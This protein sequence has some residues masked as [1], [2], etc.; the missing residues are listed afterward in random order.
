MRVVIVG[1]SAAGLLAALLLARAGH[2]VIVL[3][4]DDLRPAGDVEQ[5]AAS[6]F[7]A[8]A[9]QI[10]QPHVVLALCRELMLTHL[11]DL[12]A[13]LLEAGVVE[14]SLRSQ[15]APTLADRSDQPGDER[16]PLVLSRRATVDWVLRRW[17]AAEPGVEVRGRIRVTGL[18]ARPG[19][20]PR[21]VGVRTDTGEL[22]ADL[23]VDAAGR[24]TPL[25]GWLCDIGGRPSMLSRAECGVAYISRQYRLRTTD[26]L[27]GPPTTRRVAAL[28]QFTVGIWG[29]DH[30]SM[31][32]ALAPLVADR[33]FR[34]ANRPDV[35]A[36]VLRS[37]PYYAAWLDVLDPITDVRVMGGLHNTLRRLV[38]DGRPV[39]LG[40]LAVGDTV[41]TTNPTLA[42]G[43]SLTLR[44][45]VDLLEA[46]DKHAE[47]PTAQ[48]LAMDAAVDEHIAPFYADQ[49]AIDADRLAALRHAVLGAPPPPVVS[50]V[51][52]EVSDRV[53]YAE[54]RSAAP[55]DPG[56][57][58]AYSRLM[59][60]LGLPDDIYRDQALAARVREVIAERGGA[61]PMA[62]PDTEQLLTALATG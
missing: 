61:P 11:P 45:V 47:D 39:V 48:A 13:G 2:E 55:W 50:A 10:V 41:C 32:L 34:R 58:R 28:E 40:L 5:A 17:A 51:S 44:G 42:R 56:A 27:P 16:M 43:L 36:A 6:A 37:V 7:R 12:Y 59:G 21:V 14:A 46:L 49:A 38:V 29:G 22:A 30:G 18:L 9:P 33:R 23:V 57:F 3:E 8:A 1:G 4:R 60:A 26:G 52:S 35:F 25:D 20:P 19:H 15:M 31:Q 62:Q 24:R 54:L 53:T